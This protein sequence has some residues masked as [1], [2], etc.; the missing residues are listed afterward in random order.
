MTTFQ[1]KYK[2]SQRALWRIRSIIFDY[3]E[4]LEEKA[5]RVLHY[6]KSRHLRD[7]KAER[8]F[9]ATGPYSG[10]TRG[11]LAATGTCETDWF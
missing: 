11:E 7:R 2:M 4:Q 1:P 8:A 6:L 3:P 5:S 10:L 9:A